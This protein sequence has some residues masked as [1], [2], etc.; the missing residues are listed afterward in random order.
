MAKGKKEAP[1]PPS[2]DPKKAD[3]RENLDTTFGS[4][5]KQK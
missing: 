5:K 4:P 3:S 2:P 1:K